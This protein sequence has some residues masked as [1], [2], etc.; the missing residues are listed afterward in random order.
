MA[1][2]NVRE[3]FKLPEDEEIFDDFS[4]KEGNLTKGRMY[5]TT[6]YMCYFSNFLGKQKKIVIKW[7]QI[8]NFAKDGNNAIRVSRE[9]LP[10]TVFKE[11]SERDTSFKFIRR[12]WAN[13]SP[14]A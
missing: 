5:L 4:C 2:T 1:K 10:E 6:N 8:T 14:H 12:L 3:I 7:R 9:N 11:F 13:V